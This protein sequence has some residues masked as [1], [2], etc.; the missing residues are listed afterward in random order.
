MTF[1]NFVLVLDFYHHRGEL[2]GSSV[3]IATPKWIDRCQKLLRRL[4]NTA[5]VSL[6]LISFARRRRI[7]VDNGY[8]CVMSVDANMEMLEASMGLG[9]HKST[10]K[11]VLLDFKTIRFY[12]GCI[13]AVRVDEDRLGSTAL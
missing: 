9:R 1:C 2:N 11:L 4:R 5:G 3:Q 13:V 7:S 8:R 10:N 6:S 12:N